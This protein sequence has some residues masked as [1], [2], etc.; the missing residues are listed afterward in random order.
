MKWRGKRM[1]N[2]FEDRR[3][4]SN[5]KSL[6]SKTPVSR[7]KEGDPIKG[8]FGNP[9]NNMSLYPERRLKP[10]KNTKGIQRSLSAKKGPRLVKS[11]KRNKK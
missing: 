1:S 11:Q 3:V 9:G 5:S 4:P 10:P 7:R 8:V 6:V 2:N